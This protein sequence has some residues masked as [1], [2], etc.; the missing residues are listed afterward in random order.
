MSWSRRHRR[1][2]SGQG[3]PEYLLDKFSVEDINRWTRFRDDI[4]RFHWDYY[5]SLAYQRSQLAENLSTALLEAAE[6]PFRFSKWQRVVIYERALEPLS[7]LGSLV[8]PGGRFNVG[9]INPAQFSQFPA[10]YVA[11]D[12][13][14]AL[15]E[16]LSQHIPPG[17]ETDA[18]DSTLVRP[19]SITVVSLS[20]HLDSVVNLRHSARLETFVNLIKDFSVPDHLIRMAKAMKLTP[21]ELVR[22]RTKLVEILLEPHWRGWPMQFDVPAPCQIFGQL[23]ARAG[24]EGILYPSK[25]GGKDCLAVFPQNFDGVDPFVQLDDPS[26]EGVRVHRLDATTWREPSP[27]TQGQRSFFAKLL[28]LIQGSTP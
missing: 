24:I 6:G 21:P 5:N 3:R 20:G 22:D 9:E 2:P 15:Q 10:L 26:P 7:V 12:K 19:D 18:L 27:S 1:R 8:D 13:N 23:V 11:A 28:R 16:M 4:L 14:T 25:F 17:R